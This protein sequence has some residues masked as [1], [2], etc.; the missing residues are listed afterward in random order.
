MVGITPI[1]FS[2]Q[3][4]SVVVRDI[5]LTGDIIAGIDEINSNVESILKIYPQPVKQQCF[6][7]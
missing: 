7:Y 2:M 6:N 3:P 1:N 5:N 4:D